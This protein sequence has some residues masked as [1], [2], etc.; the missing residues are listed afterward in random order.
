MVDNELR[1]SL[2]AKVLSELVEPVPAPRHQDQVGAA[3]GEPT[4]EPR[5]TPRA[6][7]AT[8]AVVP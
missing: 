2:R 1:A 8:S 6:D 3:F 4:R 7:P 5:A